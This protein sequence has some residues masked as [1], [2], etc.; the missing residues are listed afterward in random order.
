MRP[1]SEEPM[2]GWLG[3]FCIFIF[4][5]LIAWPIGLGI[6]SFFKSVTGVDLVTQQSVS[7]R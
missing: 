2:I 7:P 6:A 5:L 3:V 1:Q 4:L